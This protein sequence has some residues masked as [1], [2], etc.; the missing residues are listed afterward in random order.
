MEKSLEKLFDF[1][2]YSGNDR[3]QQMVN[4]TQA[5]YASA[6]EKRRKAAARKAGF[7]VMTG[8]ADRKGFY[9]VP[10]G[11]RELSDD[12]LSFV[13]AAGEGILEIDDSFG[14]RPHSQVPTQMPDFWNGDDR[15]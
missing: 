14:K 6:I 4:D 15:K 9:S 11:A 2:K 13:N 5:R 3:L 8:G 1:Q 12:E 7:S 10:G